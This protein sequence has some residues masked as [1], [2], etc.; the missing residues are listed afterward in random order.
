MCFIPS[1]FLVSNYI[2][3]FETTITHKNCHLL[4][5]VREKGHTHV[6]ENDF[7]RLGNNYQ[8]N[9]K[10]KISESFYIRQFKPTLNGNEHQFHYTF[11]IDFFMLITLW[12]VLSNHPLKV[13][14]KNI[15][16]DSCFA[17]FLTLS[18]RNYLIAYFYFVLI[19]LLN[20]VFKH[21]S[22]PFIWCC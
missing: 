13:I 18:L 17:L 20:I 9:I 19:L 3:F 5:H 6:W 22:I 11:L 1:S 16:Y 2:F 7:K 15:V 21:I 12:D 10:H 14:I 4:K 8:S